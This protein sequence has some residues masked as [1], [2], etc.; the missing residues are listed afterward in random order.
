MN[1]GYYIISI[2]NNELFINV[3]DININ[4]GIEYEILKN[5]YVFFYD[6]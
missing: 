4:I 2:V 5:V 3:S 6:R 1:F